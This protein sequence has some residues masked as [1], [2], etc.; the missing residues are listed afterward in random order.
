MRKLGRAAESGGGVPRWLQAAA[1]AGRW[2][3]QSEIGCF[4]K[5]RG[6]AA[7][8]QSGCELYRLAADRGLARA[9]YSLGQ[10]M[11]K[12]KGV[13]RDDAALSSCIRKPRRRVW[14]GRQERL[15]PCMRLYR[16]SGGPGTSLF[17]GLLGCEAE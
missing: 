4:T 9:Q 1:G 3:A 14:R 11:E 7:G 8:L 2:Q 6:S 10:L 17:Y 5:M 16:R 13:K 12:G 15:A